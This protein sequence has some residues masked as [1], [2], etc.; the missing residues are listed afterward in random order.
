MP[1]PDDSG[2]GVSV[3]TVEPYEGWEVEPFWQAAL[4]V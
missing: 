3:K 2:Q 1:S 4:I